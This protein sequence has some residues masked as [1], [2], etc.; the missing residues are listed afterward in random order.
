[1]IRSFEKN[2]LLKINFSNKFLTIKQK[3]TNNNCENQVFKKDEIL[4]VFKQIN[5]YCQYRVGGGYVIKK[6]YSE[7][8]FQ[9]MFDIKYNVPLM[10]FEIIKNGKFVESGLTQFASTLRELPY[11]ETLLNSNFRL[12]TLS[13]LKNYIKDMIALFDEFVC[14]YCKEIDAGNVPE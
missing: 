10:Y 6:S 1:M 9:L 12:N 2:L 8:D 4:N 5:I 3:Y 14:E 13:D 7:Y 11:D